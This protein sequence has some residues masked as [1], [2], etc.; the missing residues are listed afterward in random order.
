MATGDSNTN[1]GWAAALSQKPISRSNSNYSI[2]DTPSF[3]RASSTTN[4]NQG[5]AELNVNEEF[6]WVEIRNHLHTQFQADLASAKATDGSV[7]VF[8]LLELNNPWQL[9]HTSNKLK[10]K[11]IKF[12]LMSEI[13]KS[14]AKRTLNDRP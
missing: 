2:R 11:S 6:N 10:T 12:N 14:L 1:G 13:N 4:I 8:K 9:N 5:V 7:V 3:P